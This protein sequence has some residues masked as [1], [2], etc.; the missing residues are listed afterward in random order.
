MVNNTMHM[1]L[2]FK[3]TEIKENKEN[4]KARIYKKE[5]KERKKNTHNKTDNELFRITLKKVSI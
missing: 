2:V 4:E 5:K 3:R 1:I